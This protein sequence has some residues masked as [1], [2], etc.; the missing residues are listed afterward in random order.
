MAVHND[1]AASALD[2]IKIAVESAS[3][4]LAEEDERGRDLDREECRSARRRSR[5]SGELVPLPQQSSS[6]TSTDSLDRAQQRARRKSHSLVNTLGNGSEDDAEKENR[7]DSVGYLGP[8]N[9]RLS[10]MHTSPRKATRPALQLLSD[11]SIPDARANRMPVAALCS[12]KKESVR[13]LVSEDHIKPEPC[14]PQLS[15]A[16]AGGDEEPISD[17][18]MGR[19]RRTKTVNYAEPSLRAKMRRTESLPGDKRRK[20]T[21]RRT[22]SNAEQMR[23]ATAAGQECISI[24]ED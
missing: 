23:Q 19:S 24:D 8:L 13:R 3:N 11:P 20:S 17:E 9:E 6:R 21:Y 2:D 14:S 1:A 10:Q 16:S 15:V 12:P 4:Q 7:V 18:T 5:L 22:S